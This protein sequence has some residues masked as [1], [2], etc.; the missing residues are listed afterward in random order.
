VRLYDTLTG[1]PVELP[2]APATIGMYVCGPTVYQRAHIG[3]ARPYVVFSW[4]ARWLRERGHDVTYVHNITDVNDKIYEA[5]PGASAERARQATEWYL[6]D[7]D[8]F[9]LSCRSPPRQCPRSSR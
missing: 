5:A 1:S 6:E 7:T 4:L 9:G 3:N 8:A 2:P